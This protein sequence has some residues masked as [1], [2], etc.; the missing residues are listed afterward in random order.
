VP[1]LY[2]RIIIKK[3]KKRKFV[4]CGFHD[5]IDAFRRKAV[6]R[7]M[8][9]LIV[10]AGLSGG[11]IARELAENGYKVT[12]VDRRDHIGGNM[13]DFVDEHGILVHKYG[14]HTFHTN[15]LVLFEYMEKYEEWEP[16]KLC[17]GAEIKGICTPTPFNYQTIDDFYSLKEAQ[18]IKQHI[19]KVFPGRETATVLEVLNCEDETVREYGEFLFEH[20][21]SLYSAK[22]WGKKPS[23]ID[24]SIL[25]RV[26]LRFSYKTGYFDDTYQVMPKHSYKMFFDNLLSH[27]NIKVQ[28]SVDALEHLKIRSNQCYWNSALIDYPVIFTG[29]IDE[30]FEKQYG[31]LPYRSLRF[32]WRHEEIDSRQDMPVV[33]YPEADGYTRIVEFKKLPYQDVDGTTYEVEYPLMYDPDSAQE[34]YYPL[35][36]E[37]SKASYAKYNEKASKVMG[38]YCCGRLGDFKYYN[39]DQALE[40][41][42]QVVKRILEDYDGTEV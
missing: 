29:P 33:A 32:E 4:G 24:P 40:R 9:A 10:G 13:F 31:A 26:P 38:L 22:Q 25:K 3:N 17:C 27:E 1:A 19:K 39:M 37:E 30:L 12:I 20:D 34:P 11:V 36:T 41:A 6:Y 21:Y 14:S 15:N 16:Y 2:R 18:K 42:L 35:L 23:E 8:Q 7:D 5:P 28:L